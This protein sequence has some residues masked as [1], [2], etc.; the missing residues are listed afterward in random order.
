MRAV[1]W[2]KEEGGNGEVVWAVAAYAGEMLE[3][4]K[5]SEI[6]ERGSPGWR[7][8]I[9]ARG[10]DGCKLGKGQCM[11]EKSGVGEKK[12]TW[13]PTAGFQRRRLWRKKN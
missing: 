10:D 13:G 7:R 11:A 6:E 3:T 2:L 9:S 12:S 1:L 8:K 4:R 5:G